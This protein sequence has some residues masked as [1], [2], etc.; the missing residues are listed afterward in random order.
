MNQ[1]KST[2]TR[3][4]MEILGS[5]HVSQKKAAKLLKSFVEGHQGENS[6]S[7]TVR[8]IIYRQE[9]IDSAQHFIGY[10]VF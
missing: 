4:N 3:Q 1:S 8:Y 2:T 6:E 7:F 10:Y 9:M 5:K